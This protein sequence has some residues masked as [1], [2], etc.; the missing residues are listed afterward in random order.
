VVV[1]EITGPI[2]I[3]QS[4]LRAGEVPLG[5]AIHRPTGIVAGL[6]EQARTVWN[7][8]LIAAGRNPWQSRSTSRL[9]VSELMRKNVPGLPAAATF[10]EVLDVIEHSRDN[11]YPVVAPGGHLVGVIRYRELS[12]ALFDPALGAVVRADDVATPAG[13]VL[14]P[15]ETADRAYEVFQATKDDC[16][17][18]VGREKP[19]QLL[20]IVRRRDLLR[21]LIR[22]QAETQGGAANHTS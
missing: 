21:M 22:S 4:V 2:L 15:D 14:H 10:D 12:T 19:Y 9:T 3:R 18:V 8:L 17:P 20:G 16:I 5:H 6:A 13:W 11:T 7:R 1:F